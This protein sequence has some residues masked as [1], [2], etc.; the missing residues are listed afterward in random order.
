MKS[1]CYMVLALGA[2]ILVASI[3]AVPDPPAVNPHSASVKAPCLREF[4]GG[5]REERVTCNSASISPHV[6]IRRAR[7]T[8]AVDPNRPSAG[9]ALTGH[10]AD[11]SP[12]VL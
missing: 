3:D 5:F 6:P 10:A 11:P 9:I 4:A 2:L 1:I 7:L 12:P 8:D